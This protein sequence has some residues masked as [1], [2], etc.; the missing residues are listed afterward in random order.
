MTIVVR[1]RLYIRDGSQHFSKFLKEAAQGDS[2]Y[3]SRLRI[4]LLASKTVLQCNELVS[5]VTEGKFGPF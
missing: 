2:L 1:L 3:I 5:S 4:F